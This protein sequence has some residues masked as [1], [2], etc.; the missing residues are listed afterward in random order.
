MYKCLDVSLMPFYLTVCIVA[1]HFTK[2]LS[3]SWICHGC[4]D[5]ECDI[6]WDSK[7]AVIIHV[8]VSLMQITVVMSLFHSHSSS[9]RTNTHRLCVLIRFYLLV[10]DLISL[11]HWAFQ[12]HLLMLR[13][14]S[15]TN[16][17]Y[18]HTHLQTHTATNVGVVS[19][20]SLRKDAISCGDNES[21]PSIRTTTP[22]SKQPLYAIH[23]TTDWCTINPPHHPNWQ[24][25]A[26]TCTCIT[27]TLLCTHIHV[28]DGKNWFRSICQI[29]FVCLQHQ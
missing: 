3:Y 23:E 21:L 14:D 24:T 22:R 25:R 27:N 18:E 10:L 20:T 11:I 15:H 12:M 19:Q 2:H 1:L 4:K 7:I 26:N 6:Q 9:I 13:A 16:R 17:H 5:W 28:R 8:E 29:G